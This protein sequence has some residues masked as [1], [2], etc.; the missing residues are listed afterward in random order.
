VAVTEQTERLNAIADDLDALLRAVER[1]RKARGDTAVCAGVE[2]QDLNRVAG[3]LSQSVG[4]LGRQGVLSSL[5]EQADNGGFSIDG[6]RGALERELDAVDPALVGRIPMRRDG[7]EDKFKAF[8]AFSLV[9]SGVPW[10]RAKNAVAALRSFRSAQ[11]Q[12]VP[13]TSDF[14]LLAPLQSVR[15][16]ISQSA[17]ITLGR[18]V[19]I[20]TVLKK[21]TVFGLVIEVDGQFGDLLRGK[22]E[23]IGAVSQHMATASA[24]YDQSLLVDPGA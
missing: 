8:E 5:L 21:I 6:V 13:V 16:Q 3:E 12:A 19:R 22:Y 15:Q 24:L 9:Q 4:E 11:R 14:G 7:I 20:V 23:V 17:A 2:R 1:E 10:S 18:A